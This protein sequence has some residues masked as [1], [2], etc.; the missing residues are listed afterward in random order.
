MYDLSKELKQ[1][2]FEVMFFVMSEQMKK[3]L[4]KWQ[5]KA[6]FYNA[7]NDRLHDI[8]AN[9]DLSDEQFD[10]WTA[11]YERL[12]ERFDNACEN[13]ECLERYIKQI[14]NLSSDVVALY[15]E[16]RPEW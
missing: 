8:D 12:T 4:E 6:D 2:D 16:I 10:K 3:D 7:L 14:E 13:Y 1:G 15:S 9:N 11:I 5:R